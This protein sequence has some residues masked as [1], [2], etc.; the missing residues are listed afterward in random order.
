MCIKC[1][2]IFNSNASKIFSNFWY[3][4]IPSGKWQQERNT[5]S[6]EGCQMVYLQTKNLNLI[7]FLER[8][9][10]EKFGISYG[11]LEYIM[12]SHLVHFMAIW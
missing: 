9:G 3:A 6:Q 5:I 2:N 11:H 10:M 8:L 4:G 1:A 7:K 12:Y